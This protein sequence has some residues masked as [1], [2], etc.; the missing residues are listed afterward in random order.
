MP[1]PL[2]TRIWHVLHSDHAERRLGRFINFGLV[3]L[4]L[5]NVL[6]FALG[7][8]PSI[9]GQHEGPLWVFEVFSIAVFS[10]EYLVRLWACT[11]DAAYRHPVFGRVR[12]ALTPLALIDLVAIV[13]F[14]LP[15]LGLDLRELRAIRIGRMLRILK[16][17]RYSEA[18]H[19]LGRV[20]RNKRTDLAAAA[21]VMALVVIVAASLLHF[22]EGEAQ[23]EY[24]GTFP[25]S[26]WWAVETVTTVGYGDVYPKTPIGKLLGAFVALLGI[27]TFAMPTA[28]LGAGFLEEANKR[29]ARAMRDR[30]VCPHCGGQLDG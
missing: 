10:V 21:F 11:A 7:T 29:K 26:L 17:G 25:G 15:W 9:A 6:A 20:F 16:L 22:A 1:E 18:L 2:K 27:G 4:I 23:P 28:I 24:F 8:I 30:R 19:M 13:P 3:T 12:W 5:L 14:Y